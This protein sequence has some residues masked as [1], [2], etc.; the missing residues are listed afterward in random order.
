MNWDAFSATGE[1]AGAIAVV[2]TL[3]YLAKQIHQQNAHNDLVMQESILDGFNTS[4]ALLANSED[5]STLI[6]RGLYKPDALTDGQA[7]QFQW[8]FRLY[9]NG[10]LKI[11]RL[12]QEGLIS[13][14]D[15][16]SH[17]STGGT[18]FNTPGGQLWISSNADSTNA[19]FYDEMR[20]MAPAD[21]GVDITLGRLENWESRFESETGGNP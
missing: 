19:D 2:V 18:L 14:K 15:W 12:K 11:Y 20:E 21:A 3:F 13:E 5:L 17:A 8:I 4:N 16:F 7:A 1:W 10:Y 6:I 9:V